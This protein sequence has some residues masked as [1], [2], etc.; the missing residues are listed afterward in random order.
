[1]SDGES[2]RKQTKREQQISELEYTTVAVQESSTTKVCSL[3]ICYVYNVYKL[4]L[5]CNHVLRLLVYID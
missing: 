4:S 1:M 2:F 3:Y 5:M